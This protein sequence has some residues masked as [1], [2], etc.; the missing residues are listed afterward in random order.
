MAA[1]DGEFLNPSRE[2]RLRLTKTK[3]K[4]VI[5]DWLVVEQNPQY[6]KQLL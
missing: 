6:P 4:P 1:S 2:V 5:S 3:E